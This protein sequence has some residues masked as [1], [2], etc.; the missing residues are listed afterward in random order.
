MKFIHTGDLHLDSPFRGL[1]DSFPEQL[2]DQVHQSTFFAWQKIVDLAI[3]QQVDFVVV[4]GDIFDREHHGVAAEDFF[5][6]QCQ[7]LNQHRIPVYLSY[8]NHDYQDVAA[9][10]LM[11]PENVHVFAN[12][13]ETKCLQL[14]DH[15]QVAL[16]GFSYG[17]RWLE[18]DLAATYPSR[19]NAD[20]HI[21]LLHG[22]INQGTD[23]HYAPFDVEE[24]LAKNYDYWAL[25][26]I[27]KHGII[28][29]QPPVVYC[30]DPQGRHINEDGEHGCYLVEEENGRLVPHFH[31]VATITWQ[32]V[33]VDLPAD[34]KT[35][36][37]VR[38]AIVKQLN[39]QSS[40]RLTI[41]RLVITPRQQLKVDVD[42]LLD[43]LQHDSQDQQPISWWVMDLTVK[44]QT[45]LPTIDKSD[46]QYWQQAASMV[47][48]EETVKQLMTDSKLQRYHFLADQV[49]QQMVNELQG[50][51]EQLL[52]QKGVS[53]EDSAN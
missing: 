15:R 43:Y 25:G 30:G 17:S 10:P 21:G 5:V 27:H 18:K 9:D 29:Q 52:G 19:V 22:A 23:N 35:L 16:T 14:A 34:C 8:G 4:V 12:Q 26:H 53:D 33:I 40:D 47:F 7:R 38:S 28:N 11:L 37:A 32:T 3:D 39:Q 36:T 45:E 48:T 50:Q 20:F 1:S 41:I 51:A 49:D 13:V 2:W 44:Q 24:L 42:R 46:L 31:P 6:K